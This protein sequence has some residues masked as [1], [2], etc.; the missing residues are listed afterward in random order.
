MILNLLTA[1]AGAVAARYWYRSSKVPYPD[2]LHSITPLGGP[3]I[4]IIEPLLKAVREGGRL[5]KIAASW[6]AV[7]AF[8]VALSALAAR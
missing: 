4:V 2:N 7:A 3:G 8:L 6:S 1:I 5:N